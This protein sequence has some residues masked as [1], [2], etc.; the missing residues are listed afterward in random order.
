MRRRCCLV[1][2][3]DAPYSASM[4]YKD[5]IAG[6]RTSNAADI[7]LEA[8]GHAD[9]LAP[10]VYTLADKFCHSVHLLPADNRLLF[11]GLHVLAAVR[12]P[13]LCD[14]LIEIA[15]QTDDELDQLFP[16]HAPISL[17][18]LLLS[19]WD[20]GTEPLLTLIEHA[21]MVPDAMETFTLPSMGGDVDLAE[22]KRRI[23]DRVCIIG[24]FDQFHDLWDCSP[25]HARRAV[26]RCFEQAGQGGD[27]FSRRW[28]IADT[29]TSR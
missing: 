27:S 28:I 12:H 21:D 23:G 10:V 19:I 18:R 29:M 25:D 6:L 15:R 20:R 13:G 9:E 16:H 22:A 14:H 24:G 26:R 7:L 1:K 11:N 2:C 17:A 4:D 5:I 8:V 3:A